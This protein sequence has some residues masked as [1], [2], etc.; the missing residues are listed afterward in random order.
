MHSIGQ[1]GT[2]TLQCLQKEM[3]TYRH[4]SVCLW[5]DPDDVSH[6]RIV[7]PDKLAYLGYTLRMKMLYCG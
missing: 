2:G 5:R 6:C 1:T 3:A 4:L 7:S